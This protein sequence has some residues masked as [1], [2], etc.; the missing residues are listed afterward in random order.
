MVKIKPLVEEVLHLGE[1]ILTEFYFGDF[2][3]VSS[4]QS[5][6]VFL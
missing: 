6:N 3:T 5:I 2:N 4:N 1:G